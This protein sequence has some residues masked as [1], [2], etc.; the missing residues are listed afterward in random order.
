MKVWFLALA[1]LLVSTASAKEIL[2]S[3]DGS[4]YLDMWQDTIQFA[5]D[6][7]CK[8]TYFVSAPYY[9]TWD[10]EL[11]HPYWALHEDKRPLL[12]AFRGENQVEGIAE[13]FYFTQAA[14]DAGCEV[15]SHLVGHYDGRP[16]TYEQW[17]KEFAF[18]KWAMSVG[19][20]PIHLK[21]ITGVRAPYMC[22]NPSYF[23]ALKDSGFLY[24]ASAVIYPPNRQAPRDTGSV[25]EVPLRWEKTFDAF[26]QPMHRWMAPFD[27]D[28]TAGIEWTAFPE[29]AQLPQKPKSMTASEVTEA[30]LIEDA[31]FNTVCYDYLHSSQPTQICLH[32]QHRAGEPFYKAMCRFVKWVQDKDPQFMTFSEYANRIQNPQCR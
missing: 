1:M 14:Q 4:G 3:F 9:V 24:D 23:R 12:I 15:A 2:I 28:W 26:K 8:F 19:M 5:K 30:K 25:E 18:F 27:C 32:F 29:M 10:Q 16:W 22:T 6:N 13:R 11:A 7:H 20:D 21:Q 17:M 31:Y